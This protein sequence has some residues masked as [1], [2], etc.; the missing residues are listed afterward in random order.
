M[1]DLNIFFTIK[2][3]EYE[4]KRRFFVS[5]ITSQFLSFNNIFLKSVVKIRY[6]TF[7]KHIYLITNLI[8][9]YDE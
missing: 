6:I 1:T 5:L 4:I 3:V 2:R 8:S 9:N 7:N